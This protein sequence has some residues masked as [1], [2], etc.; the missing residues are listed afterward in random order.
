LE[1]DKALS[2]MLYD[3]IKNIVATTPWIIKY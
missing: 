3:M 1:N 2:N